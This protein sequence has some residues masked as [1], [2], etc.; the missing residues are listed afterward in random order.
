MA[1]DHSA[2]VASKCT[3]PIFSKVPDSSIH[4]EFNIF[5]GI[6]SSHNTESSTCTA[7]ST[8][9]HRSL[10]C[11]TM[12]Y[13]VETVID[14]DAGFDALSM[15]LSSRVFDSYI[16]HRI[17]VLSTVLYC[18]M[19][20]TALCK[21]LLNILF[22]VLTQSLSEGRKDHQ[23]WPCDLANG[24]R[25]MWMQLYCDSWRSGKPHKDD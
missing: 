23:L 1:K 5:F 21:I 19:Y 15:H 4:L 12:S 11:H 20:C 9:P 8:D 24:I 25:S 6:R 17:H 22:T 13:V 18:T 7:I 3:W 16:W 2:S 14:I 10:V